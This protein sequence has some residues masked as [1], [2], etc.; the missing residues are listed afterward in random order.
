MPIFSLRRALALAT[1]TVASSIAQPVFAQSAVQ[2]YG[3]LDVGVGSFEVSGGQRD[4]RME[5]GL[6]TTSYWGV[7]GE[8][9]L[10]GGLAA[11][12]TFESFLRLDSGEEGRFTNDPL[13]SRNANVGLRGGLRYRAFRPG[14]HAVVH[15]DVELQPF[16]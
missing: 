11:L 12:F 1:L 9:D 13:F 5:S 3:L 16:R 6:M 14:Q 8:E 2:L 15:R 4:T 7:K 10:G